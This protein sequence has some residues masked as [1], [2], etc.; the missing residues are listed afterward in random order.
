MRGCTMNIVYNNELSISD[1][2]TLRKS[3]GWYD[4]SENTVEKALEKSDY[5]VSAV[6]DSVTVGMARL[7]TDGTQLL[8]MDVVVH[9]NYQRKGIGKG[10]MEHIVQHIENT[11]SQML[12]SL[13]TDEKNIGFYEKL[14]FNKIIGM[15]LLHGI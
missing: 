3:A 6:I 4:I 1:Y 10:L 8:I 2:C 15:R 13:T 9:P 7:M 14:G 12:V 5:V 11:Y